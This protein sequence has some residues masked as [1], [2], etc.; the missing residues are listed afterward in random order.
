VSEPNPGAASATQQPA[1]TPSA[2]VLSATAFL[3]KAITQAPPAQAGQAPAAQ[4]TTLTQH[5]APQAD[6]PA[7]KPPAPE[8]AGMKSAIEAMRAKRE[9]AQQEQARE[10]HYVS[11]NRRLQSELDSFKKNQHFEDD[12]MGYAE[13]RGWTKEQQLMYGK[14]LLYGLAPE[15][16]DPEFRFRMFEDKQKREASKKEA[17]QREQAT[18]AQQAAARQEMTRFAQSLEQGVMSFDA[19]SYPESEAWYGDNVEGY[20]QDLVKTAMKVADE[21]TRNRQ[22]ADLSPASLARRL[23]ADTADRLGSYTKRKSPRTPSPAPTEAPQPSAPPA[24]AAEQSGID[25]FSTRNITSG[26]VPQAPAKTDAER[27]Q[28]A[29]AVLNYR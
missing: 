3:D 7:P 4:G 6:P 26:S 5:L 28:R 24:P 19:G 17:E 18:Q 25:T 21:A 20:L 11:E 15:K 16:A 2:A 9:A 27:I 22:V 23:E 13:A 29:V 10:A 8:N 12:P 14:A 1:G